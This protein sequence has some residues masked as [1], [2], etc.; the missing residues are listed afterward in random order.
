M[1]VCVCGGGG[2]SLFHLLNES[3]INQNLFMEHLNSGINV[4]YKDLN[5]INSINIKFSQMDK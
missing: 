2:G 1:C 5:E 3:T 4:L